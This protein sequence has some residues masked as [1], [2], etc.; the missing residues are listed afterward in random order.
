MIT[1]LR[2]V[3]YI[4]TLVLQQLDPRLN[5]FFNINTQADLKRAETLLKSDIKR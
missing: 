4:S 3:R 5:T 2:N 1:R